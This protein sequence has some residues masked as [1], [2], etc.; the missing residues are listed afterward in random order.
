MRHHHAFLFERNHF[1]L[2]EV[3]DV[4]VFCPRHG[5]WPLDIAAVRKRFAESRALMKR[6]T[7]GLRPPDAPTV[8]G[9]LG[10]RRTSRHI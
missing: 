8:R 4:D 5:S 2:D 9:S 6:L 7:L 10:S 3:T 1:L